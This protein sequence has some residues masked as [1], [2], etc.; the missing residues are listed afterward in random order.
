MSRDETFL[1]SQLLEYSIRYLHTVPFHSLNDNWQA[2][3]KLARIIC[4]LLLA[5]IPFS[6][7]SYG[8][9]QPSR[10]PVLD[11]DDNPKSLDFNIIRDYCD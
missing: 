6:C 1:D 8:Q 3:L 10:V 7:N 5:W 2:Y 11:H 4:I 9:N